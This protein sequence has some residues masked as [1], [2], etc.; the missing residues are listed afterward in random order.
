MKQTLKPGDLIKWAPVMMSGISPHENS[1]GI[2]TGPAITILN[3]FM[4]GANQGVPRWRVYWFGE[5]TFSN[6][7]DYCLEKIS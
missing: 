6:P 7:F 4:A 5:N 1:V 2:I 3:D